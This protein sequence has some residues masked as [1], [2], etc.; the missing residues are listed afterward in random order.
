M[1]LSANIRSMTTC[2]LACGVDPRKSIIFQQS[3]VPYHTELAWLLGCITPMGWLNRMTQW[4]AKGATD[5]RDVVCLGLFAYPVLMAADILLY[6]SSHVP[7]GDDQLQHLELARDLA[8]SFN[9]SC[10]ST[11]FP[12]PK[13]L[14]SEVTR[15][16]SLRNPL[17]KMSKSDNQEMSRINLSDTPDEIRKKIRK[18]VTDSQSQ[19]T[20]DPDGRPGVSNLVCIYAA[21]TSMTHD[22]VCAKFEGRETV[23]FKEELSEVIIGKLEPIR[24]QTLRLDGD[25]G[26]I[27]QVLKSGAQQTTQLAES[28]MREVKSKLG[29]AL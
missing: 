28:T 12:E 15:V 4:K 3:Q 2:L 19:I 20:Y 25:P 21:L 18:A 22:E 11:V 1:L 5:N 29:I 7:V 24:Q 23:H 16:M 27:D 6:R 17:Q 13:P 26:Y 9:S 10:G 14:L 8:R